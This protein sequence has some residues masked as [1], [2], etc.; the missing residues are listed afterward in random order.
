FQYTLFTPVIERG[1][2]G[3][4]VH[5][6]K[7]NELGHLKRQEIKKVSGAKLR[8]LEI[9]GNLL[10]TFLGEKI[11]ELLHAFREKADVFLGERFVLPAVA[12]AVVLL[13]ISWNHFVHKPGP[14][15]GK[16]NRRRRQFYDAQRAFG[17]G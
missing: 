4:R 3:G 9:G 2:H 17:W 6:I 15:W 12:R 8:V 16:F 5:L 1:L 11:G 7:R 13:H 14:G 10:G